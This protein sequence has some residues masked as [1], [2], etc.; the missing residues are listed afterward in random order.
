MEI[1]PAIDK[2]LR[3]TEFDTIQA[4]SLIEAPK[5]KQLTL[6]N[7]V[8]NG[9]LYGLNAFVPF[10]GAVANPIVALGK[11]AVATWQMLVSMQF[12]KLDGEARMTLAGNLFSSAGENLVVGAASCIP[13][14]GPWIAGLM[15]ARSF[16]DANRA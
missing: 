6:Q 8:L 1:R 7:N 12:P 16:V 9:L 4:S 2:A 5:A 10:S 15:S 3:A 11:A 14:A 13:G